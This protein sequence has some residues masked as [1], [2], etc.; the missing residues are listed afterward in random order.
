[1]LSKCIAKQQNGSME[2][3]DALLGCPVWMVPDE[4]YDKLDSLS[5]QELNVLCDAN[6]YC[7]NWFR[8]LINTFSSNE[9]KLN[10][11]DQ[12]KIIIRLKNLLTVQE[13]LKKVL[14]KNIG[15]SPPNMLHL[16][17]NS[18][19]QPPTTSAPAPESKSKGGKKKGKKRKLAAA[20]TNHQDN[21]N[22]S[23]TSNVN[24]QT[25]SFYLN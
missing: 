3:L 15:Y 10:D 1:M 2:D 9:D 19:W 13:N 21:S 20:D 18:G 4:T 16:E 5:N 17:D 24:S 8:E 25:V 11:E 7:V 6:F 22:N 12:R 23:S 14:A